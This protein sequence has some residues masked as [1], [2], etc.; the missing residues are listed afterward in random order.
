MINPPIP[1]H[2]FDAML[3]LVG[4]ASASRTQCMVEASSIV[5][6]F[7]INHARPI[8]PPTVQCA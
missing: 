6:Q 2:V 3:M 5:S 7:L 8:E 4:Y 1:Q